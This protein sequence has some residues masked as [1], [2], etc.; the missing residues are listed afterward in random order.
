MKNKYTNVLYKEQGDV[1]LPVS[2]ETLDRAV[3]YK[4][5]DASRQKCGVR[6]G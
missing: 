3:G 6:I 1:Y 5:L 2:M 4:T